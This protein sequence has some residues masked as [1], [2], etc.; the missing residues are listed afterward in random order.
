MRSV[1]LNEPDADNPIRAVQYGDR[2][3]AEAPAGWTTVRV[4]A[5]SLNRHDLFALSG[6]GP[7][8][9]HLPIVLGSDAAGVDED[10]RAVLVYPVIQD[11]TG[12]SLLSERHHGTF[13]DYVNVPRANL[14]PIPPG[15]TFEE[16]ACL[17]TAWL[18]AYSMLFSRARVGPGDTVLVQGSGG[19]LSSALIMLAA[20]AGAR[21]WV[22][23]TTEA[24]K[25]YAS[26]IGAERVFDPG[27]RLPE[28]VG[29]VMDSVGASTWQHSINCLAPGGTMVVSG[30]TSGFEATVDIL[31]IFAKQLS[32]LGASLGTAAELGELIG[33]CVRHGIRPP[34]HGT[35]ALSEASAA[36]RTMRDG[37]AMGKLLLVPDRL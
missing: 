37:T 11:R 22:T 5:A 33:F 4:E 6:V 27:A 28:S 30:A 25:A 1:Y 13:A 31:W 7:A 16:A 24:K 3:L 32:I 14:V 23:G 17:P 29:Y 8:V 9:N 12:P 18:T 19:G 15:M 36:F 20:A 26:S 21:V 2:P 35:F 34:I 10:G